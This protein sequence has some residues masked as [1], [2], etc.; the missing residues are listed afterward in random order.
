TCQNCGTINQVKIGMSG[1]QTIFCKGCG[2]EIKLTSDLTL[3]GL[4]LKREEDEV[5]AW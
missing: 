4:E 3:V 2:L 5:K 1:T